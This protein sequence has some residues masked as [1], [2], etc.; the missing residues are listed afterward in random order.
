MT[1]LTDTAHGRFL[2][3]LLAGAPLPDT[4]QAILDNPA[5]A[6]LRRSFCAAY[7]LADTRPNHDFYQFVTDTL[8]QLL[9]QLQRTTSRERVTYQGQ[10]RGRVDWPATY[11]TRA[12][13]DYN[14]ALFTCRPPQRHN[15][16]PENQLLKFLLVTAVSLLQ[17]TTPFLAAERWSADG[18]AQPDWLTERWRETAFHLRAALAHVRLKYVTAPDHINTRHLLKARTSKTEWYADIADWYDQYEAVVINGRWSHLTPILGHT[19]LL[20]PP[21]QPDADLALRLAAAGFIAA[22]QA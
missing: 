22:R 19:V 4:P 5:H 20:P 9:R 16:T 8:P 18:A 3:H 11:K 7:F 14:P 6:S 12:Q 17:E 10:I 1:Q 2:S 15:D 21:D 13:N